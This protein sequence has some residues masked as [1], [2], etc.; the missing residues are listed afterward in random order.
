MAGILFKTGL[1]AVALAIIFQVTLKETV[2]LAFGV[3]RVMQP[4]SDFPYTCR[5]IVDS[6][7]EACEDMWFSES[8]RQLFLACSD[9]LARPQWMP[10]VAFLNI[11]A[12]SQRDSIVALDI[13]KPIDNSFE[14]RTLKTP[15]YPGTVGD[16]KL[17]VIGFT[18]IEDPESGAI[19]L[20]VINN[21]PSVNAKTGEL[22]DQ[23]AHGANS[24]IDL[25]ETGPEATEL[26]Y[27]RTYAD[28]HIATPNRVAAPSS[29]SFYVANDFGQHKVGLRRSLSPLLRNGNAVFCDAETGCKTVAKGFQYPNGITSDKN[30][31]VYIP[32]SLS[33]TIFIYRVLPD[34]SLKQVDAV[35]TGYS[36]DNLSIDANGDIWAAAFPMGVAIFKAYEDPYNTFPPAAALR[37]RKV[38]G[39]YVVEKVIED[40]EGEILPA[41]TT[42][43]HDV[44]TGRL[45][46]SS[47]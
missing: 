34:N 26:K 1:V 24:T 38:E 27:I 3:G 19:E 11:S 12:R 14:F 20:L 44:K 37:V 9:S 18:G 13:D 33:G 41:A 36:I 35:K 10:N 47:K 28:K 43:V 6:R 46:F 42:V 4:I 17:Q 40:G 16:G 21:G 45:F 32:C 2:W 7:I 22:L 39:E 29:S 23:Y 5:R 25:F 8:T 30:N 15:G 31:L